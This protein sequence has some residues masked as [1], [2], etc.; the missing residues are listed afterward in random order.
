MPWVLLGIGR[1]RCKGTKVG[2][3]VFY[4]VVAVPTRRLAK[5]ARLFV[6]DQIPCMWLSYRGEA[7]DDGVMAAVVE[8]L[9]P[10]CRDGVMVS[11][12]HGV[13]A[14]NVHHRMLKSALLVLLSTSLLSLFLYLYIPPDVLRAFLPQ[15]LRYHDTFSH[16]IN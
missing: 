15:G 14:M 13:Q 10:W 1:D 12:C 8:A 4:P 5:R 16:A 6:C 7:V 11:W 3:C 2:L 9:G